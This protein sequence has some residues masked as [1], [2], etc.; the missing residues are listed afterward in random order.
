MPLLLRLATAK[1]LPTLIPLVKAYHKF[2]QAGSVDADAIEC[3]LEPLLSSADFG[4][5]WLIEL[6][7]KP[8]G[9]IALCFG[10]SI[11]FGGRDAF[12]DEFFIVP[13]QRG[14]GLGKAVLA[15]AQAEAEKLDIKAL[16]LEVGQSN[17][18]AQRLYAALGFEPRERFFLMSCYLP[19]K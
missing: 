17:Q 6:E 10:Y 9:Y 3:A 14:K 1:D 4:C 11:E 5:V 2:E 18:R 12:I 16:H 13:D 8:V 19:G 7:D 15:Q